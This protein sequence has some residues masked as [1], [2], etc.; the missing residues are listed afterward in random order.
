MKGLG[1]SGFGF[2]GA[3]VRVWREKDLGKSSIRLS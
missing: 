2:E 1:V 3:A